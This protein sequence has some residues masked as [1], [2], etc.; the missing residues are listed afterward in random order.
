MQ[1]GRPHILNMFFYRQ[2]SINV[3]P[4]GEFMIYV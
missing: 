4:F 3:S 1:G 2:N